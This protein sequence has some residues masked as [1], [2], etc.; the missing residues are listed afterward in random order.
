MIRNAPLA[1]AAMLLTIGLG[2][3]SSSSEEPAPAETNQ[4]ESA[5]EREPAATPSPEPS[6]TPSATSDTNL[7]AEAPPEVAPRPDEQMLDDASATGM[8]ARASREDASPTEDTPVEQTEK[9]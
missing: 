2:A 4:V 1:L 3:C 5:D 7:T 6:P 8:T 9:K